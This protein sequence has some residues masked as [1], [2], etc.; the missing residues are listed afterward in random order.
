MN[1]KYKSFKR[2]AI[3]GMFAVIVSWTIM[4]ASYV[5]NVVYDFKNYTNRIVDKPAI[6]I[7]ESA[8]SKKLL[9][10]FHKNKKEGA[11]LAAQEKARSPIA[12]TSSDKPA[13]PKNSSISSVQPAFT[14]K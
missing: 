3:E 1:P 5:D 10:E 6:V 14:K 12:V 9:E 2:G 4:F 8:E 7:E 11:E 13:N